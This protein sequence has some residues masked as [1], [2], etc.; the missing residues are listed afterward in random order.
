MYGSGTPFHTNRMCNWWRNIPWSKWTGK[1]VIQPKGERFLSVLWN[2]YTV[3][4]FLSCENLLR[5]ADFVLIV[6]MVKSRQ[7]MEI[8]PPVTLIPFRLATDRFP[9]MSH[10]LFL[11]NMICM[12][13]QNINNTRGGKLLEISSLL[14]CWQKLFAKPP[15][16]DEWQETRVKWENEM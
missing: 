5:V 15:S 16:F 6:L 2:V 13:V 1:L 4:E 9:P 3:E 12:Y 14:S 11:P 7:G 10:C 8:S